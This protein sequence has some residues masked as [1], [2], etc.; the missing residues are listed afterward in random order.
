MNHLRSRSKI[1]ILTLFVGIFHRLG[2][3]LTYHLTCQVNIGILQQL[4]R[5]LLSKETFVQ[6]QSKVSKTIVVIIVSWKSNFIYSLQRVKILKFSQTAALAACSGGQVWGETWATWLRTWQTW[7]TWQIWQTWPTRKHP[8]LVHSITRTWATILTIAG[9]MIVG[10][11]G[12]PMIA[13]L[14]WQTCY[15]QGDRQTP[16]PWPACC[17]SSWTPSTTRSAS[18]RRR[19]SPQS[20][21]PRSWSPE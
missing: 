18:S 15:R 9:A 13:S 2:Q 10:W 17:R 4:S 8:A 14:W 7:Q 6:Y 16:R 19:S 11:M 1:F 5:R 3:I 20:S 12:M 21:E